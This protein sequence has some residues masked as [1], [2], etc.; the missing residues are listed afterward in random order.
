[1]LENLRETIQRRRKRHDLPPAHIRQA[2]R[3][4]AGVSQ[5]ELAGALNVTPA[6]V[7]RWE[8]GDR[9]PRDPML[10]DLYAKALKLMQES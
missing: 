8:S 2:I 9:T 4:R 6:A 5:R 1:M 3:R 7:C 10:V